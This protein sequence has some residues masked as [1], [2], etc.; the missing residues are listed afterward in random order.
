MFV[1]HKR[2]NYISCLWDYNILAISNAPLNMMDAE[3]GCTTTSIFI[4][5]SQKALSESLK[6]SL[7]LF[8]WN[9]IYSQGIIIMDIWYSLT[10]ISGLV[11]PCTPGRLISLDIL[12]IRI[13][14]ELKLL[15]VHNWI[16]VVCCFQNYFLN[17]H[18]S[19]DFWEC[20]VLRKLTRVWNHFMQS[21]HG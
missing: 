8:V 18:S 11:K 21:S 10:N 9:I 6:I 1:C 12:V 3:L 17:Q 20:F 14:S 2:D 5:I 16:F 7:A 13:F 19:A 15:A 4:K